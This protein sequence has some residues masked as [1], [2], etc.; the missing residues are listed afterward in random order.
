[1]AGG[2]ILDWQVTQMAKTG[3]RQRVID[4]VLALIKARMGLQML[5]R[6]ERGFHAILMPE[7]SDIEATL[8]GF[9]ND[10]PVRHPKHDAATPRLQKPGQGTQ[11]RRFPGPIGA[12]DRE[13]LAGRDVKI[14]IAQHEA[15]ATHQRN[16]LN[17]QCRDCPHVIN[18]YADRR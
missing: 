15:I 9:R 1:L 11:D 8:L 17:V 18:T 13:R 4:I 7:P 14:Q 16:P 6:S 12:T 3:T 5:E 10:R 2:K